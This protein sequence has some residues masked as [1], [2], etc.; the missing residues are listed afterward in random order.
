MK[1]RLLKV[2][3]ISIFMSFSTTTYSTGIPVVDVAGIAQMIKDGLVQ[4]QQ[5]K[6]T[7]DTAKGQLGAIKDQADHYKSMV[8]GH[9]DIDDVLNDPNLNSFMALDDWKDIHDSIADITDLRDEF[10]LYSDDPIVQANYD[11][12]MK[13]YAVQESI[14]ESTVERQ[15]KMK[16]LVTQFNLANTPAKK[17]DLSNSIQFEG[18]QIK[19]DQMML[20]SLYSLMEK[21]QKLKSKSDQQQLINTWKS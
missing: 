10:G 3:L 5:F 6:Q 21:E 16:D 1:K 18:V 9:W 2:S 17:A 20:K 14:Y 8:E 7:L 11:R 4:A 15:K 13:S 19:N 12:A